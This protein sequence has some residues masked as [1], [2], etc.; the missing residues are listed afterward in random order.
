[1]QILEGCER[2]ANQPL[3]L[4][5]E[6]SQVLTSVTS[7]F[8]SF[9]FFL[10]YGPPHHHFLRVHFLLAA[11]CLNECLPE[12]PLKMDG[13]QHCVKHSAWWAFG[14]GNPVVFFFC[15]HRLSLTEETSSKWHFFSTS[16]SYPLPFLWSIET[17]E[18]KKA[19]SLLSGQSQGRWYRWCHGKD[20]WW[21]DLEKW[22]R[23]EMVWRHLSPKTLHADRKQQQPWCLKRESFRRFLGVNGDSMSCWH[24]WA[25]SNASDWLEVFD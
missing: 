13:K 1:M 8:L 4:L 2:Y 23:L 15:S 14:F 19:K 6:G 5:V 24:W 20:G 7:L 11:G 17:I 16:S 10:S 22:K 3:S 25:S 12:S 9:I 21:A 18:Q